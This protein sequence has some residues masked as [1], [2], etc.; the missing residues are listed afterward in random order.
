MM[1]EF[2]AKINPKQK[3][4]FTTLRPALLALPETEESIEIDEIEGEWCP[5]YRVRG[6]DLVWVHFDEPLWVS[7]P[8]EPNF[9]KKVIQDENLD[10]PVI[11]AVKEAE[12]SGEIKVA[13]MNIR[14]NEDVDQI[15]PLLRLR[16]STLI[17]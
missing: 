4:Y 11:D 17:A 8:V 3:K 1:R 14:S 2:M 9:E 12:D 16:H 5:V 15:L 13:K 10:E 7:F 6:S